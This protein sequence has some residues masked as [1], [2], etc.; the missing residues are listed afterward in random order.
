MRAKPGTQERPKAFHRVDMDLMKAIAILI[1]GIFSLAMINGV[2]VLPPLLQ[3]V[4]DRVFVGIKR[5]TL[6]DHAGDNG[7]D[8]FLLNI[9]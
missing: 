6:G 3:S 5:T 1:T 2:M 8:R 9:F 7:L 4:I